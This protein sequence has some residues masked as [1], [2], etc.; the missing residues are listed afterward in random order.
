MNNKK[1]SIK[2]W[3]TLCSG[4]SDYDKLNVK[5]LHDVDFNWLNPSK[6][7]RNFKARKKV[8]R[9]L[10][11]TI[12]EQIEEFQKMVNRLTDMFESGGI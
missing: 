11:T 1:S 12:R 3:E 7:E 10:T 5:I 6:N 4:L 8:E 9:I 2:D